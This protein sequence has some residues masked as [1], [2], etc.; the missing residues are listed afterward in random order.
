MILCV[1]IDG[2][3]IKWMKDITWTFDGHVLHK[4]LGNDGLCGGPH[5]HYLYKLKSFG[6]VVI[7]EKTERLSQLGI[8]NVHVSHVFYWIKK[9]WQILVEDLKIIITAK[10]GSNWSSRLRGGDQ[11]E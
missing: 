8:R 6:L 11:I 4:L 2:V 3:Q 7:E 1:K 10:F 9:K 5:I